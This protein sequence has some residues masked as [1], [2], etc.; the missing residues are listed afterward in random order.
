[1]HTAR[2][3]MSSLIPA[4]FAVL[5][6]LPLR[7]LHLLG[8]G[9]GWLAWWLSPGLRKRTLENLALAFPQGVP[10][11]L[12]RRATVDAGRALLELPW[13]WSRPIEDVA[14]RVTEQEGY[15]R[16]EA[17]RAEGRAILLLTPHLGCF[18][19]AAQHYGTRYPITV[20]Y[21]RPKLDVLAPIM[22][23]GRLRGL[24]KAAPADASGVRQMLKALKRGEAVG[25]L[26]D[27]VPQFGEGVWAPFFGRPAYSM[28]LAAR[29]AEV[30]DVHVFMAY[31]ARLPGA[32]YRLV[33]RDLGRPLSGT[34]EQRVAQIN[35]E[36]EALIRECP[37]QYLW[38]YNR[39]KRP[40]GVPPPGAVVSA[41]A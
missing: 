21:R 5:R 36:L 4:V 24:M 14:A 7:L 13:L 26:P 33:I 32:R 22:E 16:V 29:M 6:C 25:M 2:Q 35:A 23:S 40:A 30:K 19:A 20:L 18:E 9:V 8:A 15:E 38:S 17:V 11:G 39:Y 10:S 34:P 12:A 27:Q 31:A 28:T 37:D 3:S 41:D 1:M